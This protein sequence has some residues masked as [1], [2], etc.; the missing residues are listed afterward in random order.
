M[1]FQR[2]IIYALAV[3]VFA[4]LNLSLVQ[5]FGATPIILAAE[6]FEFQPQPQ[7]LQPHEHNGHSNDHYAPAHTHPG[8]SSGAALPWSP[9]NGI[10]RTVYTLISN[11]FASIGFAAVMLALMCL[12]QLR[13]MTRLTPRRGMVWGGVGF[14][15]FFVAPSVGLPPEIPGLE[16]AA[17]EYRQQWWLSS[18]LAAGV[19]IA[20]VIFCSPLFKAIGVAVAAVPHLLGAPHPQGPVFSHPDAAV[21]ATLADLQAQF[22]VAVSVSNLLFW[23]LLGVVC[24]W[25]LNNKLLDK[26]MVAGIQVD[27]A[28]SH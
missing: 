18:V 9:D 1:L 12:L 26:R 19:G 3:G 11:I 8:M 20:M 25:V 6:A 24:A 15:V 27:A 22:I 2:I 10:E 21:V 4:G 16:A 28:A 23:L 5:Y 14:I 7:Q 17:L 13:G